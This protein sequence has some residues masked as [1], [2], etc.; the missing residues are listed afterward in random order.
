MTYRVTFYLRA[1]FI[2][3]LAI[4]PNVA[5]A[6]L[7]LLNDMVLDGNALLLP[8]NATY[9]RAINGVSFQTE[10]LLTYS[11]YQYATW[12]HNGSDED[13]YIGR[14]A[15]S[16]NTPQRSSEKVKPSR[17]WRR[18]LT[19]NSYQLTDW[20]TICRSYRPSRTIP[21]K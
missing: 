14:R 1:L 12:Y 16:G 13:V 21:E 18:P 5:L 2:L 6:Q 7:T 11:G 20:F 8:S 19:K 9:G 17:I 3:A 10:P 15:L 4:V